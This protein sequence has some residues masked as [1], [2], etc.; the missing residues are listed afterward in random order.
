MELYRTGILHSN[1]SQLSSSQRDATVSDTV[2]FLNAQQKGVTYF[3]SAQ[4]YMQVKKMR[5]LQGS[6]RKA[7]SR[8]VQASALNSLPSIC[9]I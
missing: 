2:V 7:T 3:K 1:E 4:N 8:P 6:Q 9:D 5:V